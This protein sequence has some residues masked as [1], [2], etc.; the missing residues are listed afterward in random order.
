MLW[1]NHEKSRETFSL[2]LEDSDVKA[3]QF[4]LGTITAWPC[5]HN[6]FQVFCLWSRLAGHEPALNQKLGDTAPEGQDLLGW[7]RFHANVVTQL[8]LQS[9]HSPSRLNCGQNYLRSI[10]KWQFKCPPNLK[11]VMLEVSLLAEL[12]HRSQQVQLSACEQCFSARVMGKRR[13]VLQNNAAGL[14]SFH[15][16][17]LLKYSMTLKKTFD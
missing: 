17:T 1:K 11:H 5:W 14:N 4:L 12:H 6:L 15:C 16:W 2:R 9:E 10:C 3:W 7:A 8:P 13:L